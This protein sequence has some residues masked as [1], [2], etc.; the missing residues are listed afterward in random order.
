MEREVG[1]GVSGAPSPIHISGSIAS[2][3]FVPMPTPILPP[4]APSGARIGAKSL[5]SLGQLIF[6]YLA[7]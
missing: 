2:P 5:L 6:C 4:T 1:L 7:R 3:E